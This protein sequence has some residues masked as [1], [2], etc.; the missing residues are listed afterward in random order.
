MQ[1][2]IHMYIL[3][4]KKVKKKPDE[5]RGGLM[6]KGESI[7]DSQFLAGKIYVN[8]PIKRPDNLRTSSCWFGK[9]SYK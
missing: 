6:F 2:K 4:L 9:S 5:F 7:Y 8:K 1:E 3:R